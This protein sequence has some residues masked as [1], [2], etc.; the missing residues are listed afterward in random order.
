MTT[1][2][3]QWATGTLGSAAM[4]LVID[5]PALE[6]VGLYVYSGDKVG[7]DAGSLVGRGD[8]G[9]KATNRIEDILAIDADVVLYYPM[10]NPTTDV[11]DREVQALLASGKNVVSIR[12]HRWP[13]W[14]GEAYEQ[15]FLDACATGGSTLTG[16]G[17]H[18]AYIYD[19]IGSSLTGICSYIKSFDLYEGFNLL[20][21][22]PHTI[23]EVCGL[24]ADPARMNNAHPMVVTLTELYTEQLAC[25]AHD[26]GTRLKGVEVR[27]DTAIAP[28]DIEIYCGT[29]PKGT[30]EG[31]SCTWIAT[32]GDG[33]TI[34]QNSRW[35]VRKIEGWDDRNV[36][37]IKINGVPGLRMEFQLDPP[38]EGMPDHDP[39][40]ECLAAAG[41]NAIPA[42]IAAEPGILAGPGI[43][44]WQERYNRRFVKAGA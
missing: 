30:L 16:V 26:F 6:L 13:R 37:T 19:R 27:V 12:G 28:E 22:P 43:P 39:L 38:G 7:K 14:R 29:I 17:L 8:T 9:V 15:G 3:I 21:R 10:L 18:P 25:M 32:L 11:S 24:G 33:T 36:W 31:I 4:R 34:N 40:T 41:V 20:T 35:F 23:F 44:V 42:V 1:R 2:V 5:D